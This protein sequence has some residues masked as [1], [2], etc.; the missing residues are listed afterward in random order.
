MAKLVDINYSDCFV[1]NHT[2]YK[3]VIRVKRPKPGEFAITCRELRGQSEWFDVS[4]EL[5][6]KPFIRATQ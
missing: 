5:E 1:F 4:S 6:V 3:Q 2:V